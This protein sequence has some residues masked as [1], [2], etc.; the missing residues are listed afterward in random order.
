MDLKF[1][2]VEHQGD[3]TREYVIFQA[4]KD[5][6]LNGY[7]V[8]DQTFDPTGKT[9]N[10]HR[11]SYV[12]AD[13][14]VERGDYIHLRTRAGSNSWTKTAGADTLLLHWGLQSSVWNKNGDRLHVVKIKEIEGHRISAVE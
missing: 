5:F 4:L 10:K 3:L 7:I 9:S 8:F 2:G 1:L 12:F 11:H 6:N 13:L 14:D